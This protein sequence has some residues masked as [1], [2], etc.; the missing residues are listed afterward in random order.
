MSLPLCQNQFNKIYLKLKSL[1]NQVFAGFLLFSL[2][3]L[4]TFTKRKQH[5][6]TILSMNNKFQII[7]YQLFVY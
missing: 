2:K 5:C 1:Q 7:D 6:L 3:Q 4:H